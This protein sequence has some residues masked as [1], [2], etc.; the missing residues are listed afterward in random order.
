MRA[1]IVVHDGLVRRD[2]TKG[3]HII[4]AQA[5]H[6]TRR[7][8]MTTTE[9]DRIERTVQLRAPVARVWR[10]LAD[11]RELGTWFGFTVLEGQLAPGARL[12]AR[13]THEPYTHVLCELTVVEMQPERRLSWRWHPYA[14]ESDVDYSAEPTTLVTFELAEADGGTRLTVVESGFSHLPAERRYSAF[15]ANEGGWTAQMDA[16]AR[17]VG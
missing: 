5:T 13:I 1:A 8:R 17:H 9:A 3:L 7:L 4:A 12:R 16:I 6:A 10:A 11:A 14:I 15:R 2:A